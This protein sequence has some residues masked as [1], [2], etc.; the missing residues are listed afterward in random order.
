M[1]ARQTF[2]LGAGLAA[3]LAIASAADLRADTADVAAA[4]LPPG[5]EI[6]Q[7]INAR[8][9]GAHFLGLLTLE[10]TDRRGNQRVREVRTARRDVEGQRQ[11]V[12]VFDAPPDLRGTG[13]LLHDHA[14]AARDDDQWLYLPAAR[15]VRRVA[16]GDRG[17]SFVGTDFSF[18]DMK[19]GARVAIGDYRWKTLRREPLDGHPCWVIEATPI[20][21]DV[22]AELGY[23]RVELWVDEEIAMTRRADVW[24]PLGAHLKTVDTRDIRQVAGIWTAH[25]ISAENH[26]TGQRTV[27]RLRSANYDVEPVADIFTPGA[28]ERGVRSAR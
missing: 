2:R 13:L 8:A 10:L 9:E 15:R 4:A 21:A 27:L 26:Q 16:T 5:D 12:F 20:D 24:D 25:E 14:D 19:N 6:A 18:D 3:A 1:F 22:V 11:S 28:L 23:G 17:G 7:R